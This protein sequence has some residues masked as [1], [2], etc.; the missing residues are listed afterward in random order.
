MNAINWFE[1]PAADFDRA[2]TFY[3]TILGKPIRRE[4]F[5][6]L[7]NGILPY[8][9]KNGVGG[10]IVHGDGNTPAMTGPL[11]YLN[12]GMELAAVVG[13]VEIG[14]WSGAAATH[15][16]WPRRHHRRHPRQRRQPCRP[17]STAGELGKFDL[18][19]QPPSQ[20]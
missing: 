19:T 3:E 9:P 8:E 17:A 14:R 13:R 20:G 2:V 10:S 7:P 6:G 4:I 12:T 11:V 1:I 18:T 15:P 16:N 5:A